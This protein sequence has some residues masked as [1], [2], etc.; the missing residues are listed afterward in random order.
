MNESKKNYK[1]QI[2]NKV[3]AFYKCDAE[4]LAFAN[5]INFQAVVKNYLRDLKNHFEYISK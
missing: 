1:K 5:T 2:K 3:V 4:L